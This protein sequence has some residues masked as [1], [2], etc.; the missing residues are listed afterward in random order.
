MCVSGTACC[1][2]AKATRKKIYGGQSLTG[3]NKKETGGKLIFAKFFPK[4]YRSSKGEVIAL[5]NAGNVIGQVSRGKVQRAPS[6]AQI[7]FAVRVDLLHGATK[8]LNWNEF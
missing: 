4:K 3:K 2:A 1:C 7:N 6:A 5:L 8:E